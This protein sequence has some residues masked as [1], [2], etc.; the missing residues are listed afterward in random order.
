MILL[1][2]PG[3]NKDGRKVSADYLPWLAFPIIELFTARKNIF[4]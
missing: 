1:V 2:A 4:G 3:V